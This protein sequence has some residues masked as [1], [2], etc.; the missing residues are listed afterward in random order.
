MPRDYLSEVSTAIKKK[1]GAMV[2][3]APPGLGK[4]SLGAAI[5]HRVFLC[6]PQED[7]I[8]TLKESNLVDH[9]IPV[10]P[11][12]KLWS[13][14]LGI[15]NALRDREHEFRC[16]VVDT[17]GGM[18]RL[19]HEHVCQRDYRGEWGEKG[20][21]SYQKGF[22]VA[23][24]DW[25]EFLNLLD[26]LRMQRGMSILLLAHSTIKPYKNPIGEDYDR[27]VPDCHWKT[28]SI[29]HKWADVVLFGNYYTVVDKQGGRAKGRGG[30]ERILYTEHHAAYEAKNR[31]G[32]PSE[33]SMG[34]S[35]QEAWSNLTTAIKESMNR[36]QS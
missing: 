15:L 1:P 31:Y 26:G 7:G 10:L 35:G 29:T 24:T 36:G 22:E 3:F 28:W 14:V 27:Y 17:L 23:L 11:T 32:L 4:T 12:P 13:D 25:R 16:L 33:I 18:E 8:N 6:D 2:M 20:F 30:Q 9:D 34:D 21:S 5:P 19:C